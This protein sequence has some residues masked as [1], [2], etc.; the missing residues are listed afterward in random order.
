[1][2]YTLKNTNGD[3]SLQNENGTFNETI[4]SFKTFMTITGDLMEKKDIEL[5]NLHRLFKEI[6]EDS[7]FL[8]IMPDTYP[9]DHADITNKLKSY[10]FKMEGCITAEDAPH[11]IAMRLCEEC[12]NHA[13]FFTP[14]GTSSTFRSKQRGQQ[15]LETLLDDEKI[16]KE[17]KELMEAELSAT[18]LPSEEEEDDFFSMFMG[19]GTV[20]IIN[21]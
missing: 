9:Q 3:Y 18:T 12:G 21:M 4:D 14:K 15:L 11:K 13:W 6:C 1:M 19:R 8:N 5:K 7:D 16:T 10:I 2:Q 20:I 17:A